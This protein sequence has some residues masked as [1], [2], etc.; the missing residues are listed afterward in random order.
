MT[1]TRQMKRHQVEEWLATLTRG[2]VLYDIRRHFHWGDVQASDVMRAAL[3]WGTVGYVMLPNQRRGAA[4]V[5]HYFARALCPPGAVLRPLRED[6]RKQPR[7][8]KPKPGRRHRKVPTARE[9]MQVVPPRTKV[10]PEGP[11][12]DNGAPVTRVEMQPDARYAVR[13]VEP[14]F[15]AGRSLPDETWASRVYEGRR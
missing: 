9:A 8:E 4:L 15:S 7:K 13:H 3:D 10:K 2:V 5:K 12:I 14:F 11:A 6:L 1:T